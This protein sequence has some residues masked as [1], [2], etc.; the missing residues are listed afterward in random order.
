MSPPLD[1][2]EMPASNAAEVLGPKAGTALK[3]KSK[4]G[5]PGPT[6]EIN[7]DEMW[8]CNVCVAER[9]PKAVQKP[10]GLGPFGQ[11]LPLLS[12][13]NP[14]SFQLPADVR[15]Y[16]K[17]VATANDGDY[18]NGGMLRQV[19][20]NKHGLIEARDPYRLK[21]KNGDAVLCYRCGGTALP[22]GSA[23]DVA[24]SAPAEHTI[25]EGT[26]WRKIVSCDFCALHWH[27]D[28]VDP[29]MLGMPSNLRKWMCP[30]HSDHVNDR[31]RIARMGTAVPRTLDLPLPSA[32]SIGPG[33]HFRTR[34]LNNGDIDIIPDPMELLMAATGSRAACRPVSRRSPSFLAWLMRLR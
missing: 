2:D 30:A 5:T 20:P 1:I 25:R 7:T 6:T 31:R 24:A 18:V 14:K 32:K 34:V 22:E 33:K 3:G 13:Q 9:K 12:L 11:L 27:I 26:G 29:P 10:K 15:T 19:K 23:D 16:F 8:F 17:D 28:C 21:D 4:A